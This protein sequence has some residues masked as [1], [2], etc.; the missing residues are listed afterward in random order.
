[1]TTNE[2]NF[3]LDQEAKLEEKRAKLK[4]LMAAKKLK[5]KS[6]VPKLV[7]LD[8]E[9]NNLPLSF[10]QQRLW[11]IDQVQ[12]GSVEYNMP[13]VLHLKGNL[14]HDALTLCFKTIV[15]RHSIL[16]TTYHAQYGNPYQVVQNDFDFS[17]PCKDISE[18]AYA[19]KKAALD[20]QIEQ[21]L[22]LAFD[23]SQDLMI[24]GVLIKLADNEHVLT[25]VMHHIA[26]DGWSQGVMINELAR[27]YE[28]YSQNKHNP[29]PST[30]LQYSDYAYW[31]KEWLKGDALK[32]LSSYWTDLLADIPLLHGLPTDF[33]RP[34]QQSYRGKQLDRKLPRSTLSVLNQLARKHNTTLFNVL[35][36]AFSCLI[37]RYSGETD[38]VIG[39]P[40]ANRDNV[41]VQAMI[42]S[43]INNIVIRTDVS[44]YQSFEQLLT[45]TRQQSLASFEHQQMPFDTLV[46]KLQPERSLSFHPIFQIMFVLQNN[47]YEGLALSGLDIEVDMLDD[48]YARFDITL[49]ARESTE[50]ISF[51]W[52]YATDLFTEK[53]INQLADSFNVMLDSIARQP[54]R[55][56]Q[57]L[58]LL[59][60]SDEEA[61]LN[62]FNHKPQPFDSTLCIHQLFEQQVAQHSDV[63]A[64]THGQRSLTYSE[65]NKKANQLAH[66]L[67]NQG[68]K[69]DTLV[70]LS[71]NRS[72]DMLV[73]ILGIL[74]AGGA[75]VAID[76]KNPDERLQYML[77]NSGVEIVVTQQEFSARFPSHQVIV[78][79]E[80]QCLARLNTFAITEPI[81]EIPLTS[82]N[83]AYV[84]YTSGST[85]MPKGVMLQH[86]GAV[87]LIQN[88]EPMFSVA[89]GSQVLQFAS[90]GF[91]AATWE[92]M[93]ALLNGATL[94]ICSDD[95]RIDTDALSDFLLE[96]QITHA[97]L[98]PSL[99]AHLDI[100][101]DYC[102]EVLIV[103]GEA[104][105]QSLA[106]KWAEKFP[107]YN[108]Y[109]PSEITV[110]A[111]ID[112]VRP[113]QIVT[114][115]HPLNNLSL[116]VLDDERQ[117]VPTGVV[118]ELYVSGVGLARG[119]L[120]RKELTCENFFQLELSHQR[121]E[122][123]YKTGDLVRWLPDGRLVFMGRADDQIKIRGFRIELGEIEAVLTKHSGIKDAIVLAQTTDG[124]TRLLAWVVVDSEKV[125][126]G[127][128]ANALATHV[129]Q[130]LPHYMVPNAFALL[131]A[132]PLTANGKV[133][134][135]ALPIPETVEINEFQAAETETERTLAEIWCELLKV[136]SVGKQSNFFALGGHS[137]M[138]TKLLASIK[139]RWSIE[140]NIKLV[141][142]TQTLQEQAYEIDQALEISLYTEVPPI[143]RLPNNA[144]APLSY[145]QQRLW[146]I[147]Q[148]QSGG[149]EYNMS[150]AIRLQGELDADA[151]EMALVRII[152][153]H[154]I[155]K[156][157]YLESDILEQGDSDLRQFQC[158]LPNDV[159]FS[160]QRTNLTVLSAEQ[161]AQA[162]LQKGKEQASRKFD[163]K[164][165]FMIR[166]ELL[167]LSEQ[168]HI[169]LLTLHHIASDGW[170]IGLLIDELSKLYSAF[171]LNLPDPLPQLPIQY[172]DYAYWQR[173]R[174][175]EDVLKTHLE[176]WTEQLA[177]LPHVHSLPLDY[178]RPTE[179]RFHGAQLTQVIDGE[180]LKS[181]QTLSEQRNATLFMSL[182]AL[183]SYL[184]GLYSGENDI[185][186]GA[187]VANRDQLDTCN[188]IGF[189][190][191]T[192]VLRL[193]LSDNPSFDTLLNRSRTTLLSA[194]EHQHVPF[195]ALVDRLQ[196]VR[197]LS[198]N[199]LFQIMLS[200]NNTEFK[201][202][203]L[204]DVVLSQV[205]IE[206]NTAQFDLTLDASETESGLE[207][208]WEYNTELF[209]PET[210]TAMMQLFRQLVDVVIATP[211]IPLM[212][213]ELLTES[214]AQDLKNWSNIEPRNKEEQTLIEMFDTH[215][216]R[217]AHKTAVVAGDT[218]LTYSE[219]NA[220]ANK[221]ANQLVQRGVSNGDL[222]GLCL[223]R[224]C[225][226]IIAILAVIKAG[227]AYL[228][229]DPAYPTARLEHMIS[230]SGV[231]LA[232]SESATLASIPTKGVEILL[233][234][235]KLTAEQLALESSTLRVPKTTELALNYVIYTSGSTGTPKGVCV[236]RRA[237]S[238]HISS[239]NKHYQV[240]P[241]DRCVLSA[242]VNFD[243]AFEQIFVPLTNG[244]ELHILE[245]QNMPA[246]AFELY[247]HE[248]EVTVADLPLVY[249]SQYLN[250]LRTNGPRVKEGGDTKVHKLKMLIV[251]G[252]VIPKALVEDCYH[253]DLCLRFINAY[254]PTET[255]VTS[256][257]CTITEN[258]LEALTTLPVGQACGDRRL[259]VVSPELKRLPIGVVGELLIGGNCLADGYLGHESLTAARFFD[260]PFNPGSD[261]KVYRTGDLVRF[262]RDG[263]LEFIGR[264][265]DQVKLRGFRI[266]LGE[267]ETAL[268]RHPQVSQA[269]V[270]VRKSN[271]GTEQLVAYLVTE[272][273]SELSSTM[274]SWLSNSLPD[275]M[276]PSI[277][278]PLDKL[279]LTASEK[280]DRKAL[281]EVD[282]EQL[283][284]F[285]EPES[286]TEKQL[287]QIWQLLLFVT[288]V[289][290]ES[291]FFALG[292]HSLLAARLTA[293]IRDVW[294]VEVGIKAIFEA[295]TLRQLALQIDTVLAAGGTD[296]GTVMPLMSRARESHLPLSFSQQRLWFIDQLENGSCEYNMPSA[297]ELVGEL[298]VGAL[299]RAMNTV[300][301]RHEVLRTIY[302]EQAQDVVQVVLID[303]HLEI[304]VCDLSNL[305]DSTQQKQIK[306]YINLEADTPF[307]LNQSLM[308][309]VK[310]LKLTSDNAAQQK[311]VLLITLHHIASDGW[312]VELMIAELRSLY[313]AFVNG[314]SNPLPPLQYQYADYAYS[315]R[316]WLIADE[317]TNQLDFWVDY[318]QDLPPVHSL[319]LDK[320]RPSEQSYQGA[321]FN[322]A[323]GRDL[324]QSIKRLVKESNASL[325][326]LL[327]A[328]FSVL[329]NRYSRE[330]DI[331]IG[332]P[333]A[334]R[335]QSALEPII[336]LFVNTLV[337][338]TYVD[339]KQS[340]M[341]LLAQCRD[342]VMKALAHQQTPFESIVERLQPNRSLSYNPL[343]QIMLSVENNTHHDVELQGVQIRTIE[344][345]SCLSQFDL[346]LNVVES[347]DGI[348]LNWEYA[349]S[350]FEHESILR[351]AR[352]FTQ[353]LGEL[354]AKPEVPLSEISMLSR[355]EQAQILNLF[356]SR[357]VDY[358]GEKCIH[359]RFEQQVARTPNKV[360]V[361]GDNCRLTY[362]ELNMKA[363]KLAHY[364]RDHGVCS[365]QLVGIYA[366]RSPSFL[367]AIMAILKA[368]GAYVPLDTVNPRDR[369]HYMLDDS[370]I[371]ILLTESK[372][373]KGLEES[374]DGKLTQQTLL[375]DGELQQLDAYDCNNPSWCNTADDLAYMIYTSGS[376]GMPKGALV[377]HAGAMNHILAE[378][379]VLGFMDEHKN[380]LPRNFLQS[381]ASSSDVSVWQFLAPLMCGGKTVILD[382]MTNTEKMFNL[383]R[384]QQ[385]HLMQAAPVVLQ[386]FVDYL[387]KLLPSQ[388][389]LSDLQWMMIIAE[390][391]PVPLINQWFDLCP[392]I[393]IMNGYGPSEA[394]DDITEYIIR[395]RLPDSLPNIPIGKP[396]PNL[397]MYV[398][399]Q[400]LQ[401]QPVG[402]PGELCVSGV[403]VGPGYWK[404]EERT[405]QSFVRNPYFE[406][407]N[408]EVHG[409]RLYRT[410][411]LGRWLPD[412][413]LEFM[414]RIDNQVKVR[415]FRV[416]LGEIEAN[417]AKLKHV[418]EC[419]VIIRKDKLGQN[420]IAAY[421]VVKGNVS[422]TTAQ[423]RNALAEKLP[424]YM[425]PSSFTI[426][427]KMPLNAADKINRNALPEPNVNA[428]REY[429]KPTSQTEIA[430]ATMWSELLQIEQISADANFFELGGHSLLAARLISQIRDTYSVDISVRAVFE[431]QTLVAL[432]QKVEQAHKVTVSSIMAMPKEE[433]APLSFAQQ[434]MWFIQQ[435]DPN[436]CEY[437][438]PSAY[439]L[440]GSLNIESLQQAFS[441][442][443]S[444]HHV[445]HT[446]F[447]LQDGEPIVVRNLNF[448]F[449]LELID[450]TDCSES[451]QSA[452]V[453]KW[454]DIE[455][456]T[457]F[458]L[459]CDLMLRGKILRLSEKR[460]ILLVTM[461]HIA[462]D[463]WSEDI[464][465]S[466]LADLYT[467]ILE[468][469]DS[470]LDNLG[471][472]YV[473]YAYWQRSWLQKNLQRDLDYWV[474]RL[475][476]L[477]Q[478]HS[479]PLDNARPE[480]LSYCAAQYK[481]VLNVDLCNDL[482]SLAQQNNASLF[483]AINAVFSVLLSRYSGESDIVVG[484]PISNREQLEIAPLI[485]CF[486]NTLVLRTDLSNDPS[487]NELLEQSRE[488]VLEAF[489]HQQLPFEML[490]DKLKPVRSINYNPLFQI[491][492]SL[493]NSSADTVEFPGL[494]IQTLEQTYKTAQFDLS[495]DISE[496]DGGL[497][498]VWDYAVDLFNATTIENMAKHFNQL[499]STL[500]KNPDKP[501]SQL[502]MLTLDEQCH[503]L[504]NFNGRAVQ[505]LGEP[506]IHQRFE[507]QVNIAADSIAVVGD[508]TSLSYL[509]LN[510]KANQ[511][512]HYLRESGVGKNTLVG[513]YAKRSPEF[514]ISILAIMKA[515]GAY[516]PLD[517]V[518]PIERIE[519]MIMDSKVAILIS[520]GELLNNISLDESIQTIELDDGFEKLADWSDENPVWCNDSQDL[521]YMIYTSGSTGHPKGALVHHAGA[522]NHIDAEFDVLGFM[523]D[524]HQ[525]LPKN[526]LQSAASSSD[527]SVW[528]F[529]A[530]LMCGGKTVI[531]DD[532]SN[533][534]KLLNLLQFNNIHLVQ[535]APVVL[536][537]FIDYLEMLPAQERKL[538]ELEWV[539]SIGEAAPVPLINHWL[540]LYP[541]IPVMNGYGPS[542]ASDDI[543]EYVIREPLPLSTPSIP[544]G[545]PLPNLTMYVLDKGLQ[546]Q[547]IGIPGELCVSG[548]GVGKGYWG[549]PERTSQSF[550][551]NP[552][553]E[554]QGVQVH[555]NTLYKTGDLGRWLP[556]GTL[557]YIGRMDSQVK[558]RGFRVE[559]GEIEAAL[560]KV[561]GVGEC[562]VTIRQDKHGSN[563][564]AAY[565]VDKS[566]QLDETQLRQELKLLLPEY[567]IPASFTVMVEMPLNGADKI[568]RKALPEPTFST[569]EDFVQ[570]STPT[571]QKLSNIW[572][573]L[574]GLEKVSA[575]ANFFNCGGHSVLTVKLL[576]RIT[577]HF[578]CNLSVRDIFEVN[579]LACLARLIDSKNEENLEENS[580]LTRLHRGKF[581]MPTVYF[582]PAAGGLAVAYMDIASAAN[583][584]FSVNAFDHRGILTDVEPHQSIPEMVADFV[585]EIRKVQAFGPYYI[586]GHSSGGQVAYEVALELQRVGEKAVAI[587]IDSCIRPI[588]EASPLLQDSTELTREEEEDATAEIVEMFLNRGNKANLSSDKTGK[589]I[590]EQFLEDKALSSRFIA[591]SK[592][593]EILS[594]NYL[595][596]GSSD[597]DVVL[598]YA[599]DENHGVESEDV[600]LLTNARIYPKL[601]SGNH[602]SMLLNQ[603][604]I[605][606]ANH[607]A[608]FF[609]E[610]GE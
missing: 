255:L 250:Y 344:Q 372:L 492:L 363:N 174:L 475:M 223:P 256:T 148:M 180:T 175:H 342:N 435:A 454:V 138:A 275:Y 386:L 182:H 15:D 576:T 545:R 555:G 60:Q 478:V 375:L 406:L 543:T 125:D 19:S 40:V 203:S 336:G 563:Y 137:L 441:Q 528:Q 173:N 430:L 521:A 399:D 170:S 434:R 7:K 474:N 562:A 439:Q 498:L 493:D 341:S 42:G 396:L 566:E 97:L 364:L 64:I 43:F 143:L 535:T 55:N 350:L 89:E 452:A 458:D 331:V 69:P 249:L 477:P 571:E 348:Q 278:V 70:G 215:V 41:D 410:G 14:N 335:E 547:P 288:K 128:T 392:A 306:K 131:D 216:E 212:S 193:D 419:A 227:G 123:V 120:N 365:G 248:H 233:L 140:P 72:I 403:G 269:V 240:E 68:V 308:L 156:T 228:P 263:Q 326:I 389:L 315:Q 561:E 293:Q 187:P 96:K 476:G 33:P 484:T 488:L 559:I 47:D 202:L 124:E 85:G 405:A 371:N 144:R 297:F 328:A 178:Q 311:H 482:K 90:L 80:N 20:K 436:G 490:V 191:N 237:A 190:V 65:L 164:Q 75:Y 556:D 22:T 368:G 192:V 352:H 114:I 108:A 468:H 57:N 324:S 605:D 570:P 8:V 141:F 267:I 130:Y 569:R 383:L 235:D 158:L 159:R 284:E 520:S 444:R 522:L 598:I 220:Q 116:Y 101:R 507:R 258:D 486:I 1:M 81:H 276:V 252:E 491:M 373:L 518:N 413:N 382:D 369:I 487:M 285:I 48:N 312:S 247:L 73:G 150:A 379:D 16:R 414:G 21:L 588:K 385:V 246:Q 2:T 299:T 355:E 467:A 432:S 238:R 453:R 309:R 36:T 347:E 597:D 542:E 201:E 472:Q 129:K 387:K 199:P 600:T 270:V 242:S 208:V 91:D 50:G 139:T 162:I 377:H 251:G 376:T 207:L 11:N 145:S 606:I 502:S 320:V 78:I 446:C 24:R 595:P 602:N 304:E 168:E 95:M 277:Y 204:N 338:R 300:L 509:E 155:L 459:S 286:E 420:T 177:G 596:T 525:L 198:H 370:G 34:S 529:L 418:G 353:L 337:I 374:N 519:Y 239:I 438:M 471:V 205:E 361:V 88:R 160:I 551:P 268:I 433:N 586:A 445:L 316:Q 31:Q 610:V 111:S 210:I 169:L 538:D 429:L 455:S 307:K 395:E 188:L 495:L 553:H 548:I 451:E 79:D 461:H 295:Q 23:L 416:E 229:L 99:L 13:I 151:L 196:P 49:E 479:L 530:P 211:S 280:V 534:P 230:D 132:L 549:N 142:D 77:D 567:M 359:H 560:A 554:Y 329:L 232:I 362:L 222:V 591:V 313:N 497:I 310:L 505:Y 397:T 52:V 113:N 319:P 524:N 45:Q 126:G 38:I 224:N 412:G 351:M 381:A 557:E 465:L 533:M 593:H 35:N 262:R 601:V 603:G 485:G 523:G 106:W 179:Q 546:I 356:N 84:I 102:F 323:L 109:G 186:L 330:S 539:M 517:P 558:V 585:S 513:I 18:L 577:Q 380:L 46:E 266:E 287:S 578:D 71:I 391:A 67:L 209:K 400:D 378:F 260:D 243:A 271:I 303:A 37:A 401:L 231:R 332:S 464:L 607:I 415:G 195:E 321:Q 354:V 494:D 219:L 51:N 39:T 206:N 112:K 398:L 431:A 592:K 76:T 599:S 105:Q 44:K 511:L 590:L 456:E 241:E 501:V 200:L 340:F 580:L 54:E 463:G 575:S 28:A 427:D 470:P 437:N 257:V 516:V 273:G 402:V 29:L 499:V 594:D 527:I 149:S 289:G 165:D 226:L 449:L 345:D 565:I 87:N 317:L 264:V 217:Y 281:P 339:S 447:V 98:P 296:S 442:I 394:S 292:G 421:L 163:L 86:V 152:D 604:A 197:S 103:G 343:F 154:E 82:A 536:Q 358:H 117:V 302:V 346:S 74:K 265:D 349:I 407:E 573:D 110:C 390:A 460:H 423:L 428:Q 6:P 327:N 254:G 127:I 440:N 587:L 589:E 334:N 261:Q 608:Q 531:L 564:L 409:S 291:N 609:L 366:Q 104:C 294:Q 424:D 4:A 388:S 508:Y 214:E 417:L 526:F 56:I 404:N 107:L 514:L 9:I 63:I 62:G 408:S 274:S 301:E 244:A 253:F 194:W 61:I 115:G 184:L 473:D 360:A 489:E 185:V 83:L 425:V 500:V 541:E 93:M 136:E 322:S 10:S 218:R 318:L 298:D 443:I 469:K 167:V 181:I 5:E 584:R 384:D 290:R 481:T 100:E 504:N 480:Q 462:S 146:F 26:S 259:Y 234:D 32:Q 411:D 457:T 171:T 66:C 496:S 53:S 422:V 579:T 58:P 3:K 121:T 325:F 544:I 283:M 506:C 221:L 134:K 94:H 537:L 59:N 550:I 25:L 583:Q 426:L 122:R 133:N 582:I 27:L 157:V 483:M 282:L 448:N 189:F 183:F 225:N 357:S 367:V 450:L 512:A 510:K 581:D 176:Y 333:V 119:Y 236:S 135:K 161:Q 172:R 305:T 540:K 166:G 279:P 12:G 272:C 393:Q 92:W 17:L 552:F 466:E 515:G 503:I 213:L 572:C 118:G 30:E 153:R 147:D 532:M 245:L 314:D 568:D 574:L